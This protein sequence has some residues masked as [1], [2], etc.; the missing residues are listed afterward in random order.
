MMNNKLNEMLNISGTDI[1]KCMRCGRCSA[2]CPT[3]NEME[4]RPHQFISCLARGDVD[5]AL[6]A[7]SLWACLACFSC[8]QR[9]PR[10]VSPAN[11]IEAARL[12]AI[13][14]KGAEHLT[15]ED[16]AAHLDPAMPQQLL[17]AA[18]RKYS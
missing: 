17:V 5:S 4:L 16:A 18:F 1:N 7:N 14:P 9:C 12:V 3:Y 13:R 2:A 11:L 6:N 10:Q 8:V 15:P